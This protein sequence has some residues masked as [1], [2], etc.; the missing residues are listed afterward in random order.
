MRCAHWYRTC[1]AIGRIERDDEYSESAGEIESDESRL[2]TT[3]VALDETGVGG[4]IRTLKDAATTL[5]EAMHGSAEKEDFMRAGTFQGALKSV[6]L[7]ERF[8]NESQKSLDAGEMVLS[9][10]SGDESGD[11]TTVRPK[12]KRSHNPGQAKSFLS[13]FLSVCR[14]R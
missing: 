13:M 4:L 7:L 2:T 1:S 11:K 6:E 10:L 8:I 12:Q 9:S 14:C 5:T 3:D